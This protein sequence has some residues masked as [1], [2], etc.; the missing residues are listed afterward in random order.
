MWPI[1]RVFGET[2]LVAIAGRIERIT[3]VNEMGLLL[4]VLKLADTWQMYVLVLKSSDL[5]VLLHLDVLGHYLLHEVFILGLL[6][7]SQA[8][9]ISHRYKLRYLGLL[10]ADLVWVLL[11]S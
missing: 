3:V 5:V 2:S 11:L 1:A 7:T 8:V 4:L 9:R 6:G 10:Q